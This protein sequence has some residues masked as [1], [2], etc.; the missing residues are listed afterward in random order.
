MKLLI[1]FL[2]GFIGVQAQEYYS[3]VRELR[4]NAA[5]EVEESFDED[6]DQDQ[7]QEFGKLEVKEILF[8]KP[9]TF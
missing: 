3:S 6:Q 1:L 2:I 8:E 7:D 5:R 4:S 9:S